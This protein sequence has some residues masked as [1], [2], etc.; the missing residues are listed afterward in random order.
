MSPKFTE[1]LNCRVCDSQNFTE[2]LNLGQMPMANAFRSKENLEK[3]ELKFPLSLR[4]CR[5][6]SLVQL[7][8]TVNPKLLFENYSYLTSASKPLADHF[9]ELAKDL[10]K[11]YVHS[12]DDLVVEIGSNDGVLLEAIKDKCHVLGIEP[13]KNVCALSTKRGVETLCNFFD[14]RLAI[15]ISKEYGQAKVII[16][17]NVVAHIDNAKDLVEGVKKLMSNDGVFVFEV[18]WVG[19]LIGKGGFDQIYHEHLSYFSLHAIQQLCKR[20][21]LKLVD[22]KLVPIHGESLQCH[23]KIKGKPSAAVKN[24]LNKEKRLGLHKITTYRKFGEKVEKS[25]KQLCQILNEI[26]K[27]EKTVIGYGAPAKGN[28]LLNYFGIGPKSIDYIIDTTSFKQGMFTP[29]AKIQIMHPNKIQEKKPDYV[30]LL[31]WNYAKEIL[32]KEKT[33][34]ASGVKFIIPVP[35]VR[36]I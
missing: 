8:H 10:A 28:T 30:L 29:G 17:N 31:S 6:C 3:P 14:S 15:R 21:G 27:N 4:F 5:N 9:V 35:H 16:A 33:L 1:K 7:A 11:K 22:A 24:I 20:S 19:N 13:A 25:K 23:I 34:R 26:K 2:I 36:I 12:E 18:H 32:E